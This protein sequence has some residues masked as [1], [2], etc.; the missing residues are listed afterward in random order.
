MRLTHSFVP[1]LEPLAL[2][3]SPLRT[4]RYPSPRY[5]HY[6]QPHGYLCGVTARQA[7]QRRW[8]HW[9]RSLCCLLLL[10]AAAGVL[11][12]VLP[13]GVKAQTVSAFDLIPRLDEARQAIALGIVDT[14]SIDTLHGEAAFVGNPFDIRREG[15]PEGEG[16]RPQR[17]DP[18]MAAGLERVPGIDLGAKRGTFDTVLVFV[19]LL[20]LSITL[21][22]QGQALRR[23]L[24]AAVNQNFLSRLMREQQ[25]GSYYVWAGLGGLV[26]AAYLYAAV[27][28]L[29]PEWLG[30]RWTALDG[31]MLAVLG[32][33]LL[34]LAALQILKVAF[35]LERQ[36]ETYQ[37][38]IVLWLGLLGVGSFPLLVAVSFGP[39]GLAETLAWLAAPL[40]AI[41]LLGRSLV[42]TVAAGNVVLSYPL[43]FFLYLCALEI[44]PLLVIY[45]WLVSR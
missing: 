43:H 31:F 42:A 39:S 6:L 28:E 7:V 16:T 30:L 3:A 2:L 40:L 5:P 38:L 10:L 33:T 13:K 32:L 34:K 24:H 37:M 18:I 25:R 45:T 4:S 23:M 11:E 36:L 15:N 22:V 44:G 1:R 26:L 9:W 19:F 14:S 35:P 17:L 8:R 20:L 41:G 21:I 29:R 12:G 27:R